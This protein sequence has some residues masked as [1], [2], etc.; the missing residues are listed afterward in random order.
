[1]STIL[2]VRSLSRQRDGKAVLQR[3]HFRL[4]RGEVMGL[5]GPNG[6]G[7]T[8][9]LNLLAGV[10][11]PSSGTITINGVDLWRAPQ[12]AKRALGYL[13]ERPPLYPSMQVAEYLR[14]C[15][16]LRRLA[17]ASIDHA[18]NRVLHDCGLEQVKRRLLG[19]LSKGY[20]QRVGVAQALIHQPAL[21]LLDEPSDGLD[22]VQAAELRALLRQRAPEC[23]ILIASHQL[24]DIE[25]ICDQ[26]LILRDGKTLYQGALQPSHRPALKLRLMPPVRPDTLAALPQIDQ[27]SPLA[28][29]AL[30]I[31]LSPGT[32]AAM[33]SRAL[34]EQ[35]FG[36]EEL[37]PEPS[38]LRQLFFHSISAECAP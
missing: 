37:S 32:T 26:V 33:L 12:Q 17:P 21:V 19:H 34:I 29:G 13:P 31:E 14:Y 24:A 2:D 30:R 15:A 25:A 11:K 5:L 16:Q 23:A 28:D 20:R 10:L 36:L 35:G 18:L 1:M 22:P 4:A 6:A 9:C 3:L 27:V 38:D 8:T 7:K